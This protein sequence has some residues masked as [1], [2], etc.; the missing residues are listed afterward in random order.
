M[1]SIAGV[2]GTFSLLDDVTLNLI[3]SMFQIGIG[4]S[5]MYLV[6]ITLRVSAANELNKKGVDVEFVRKWRAQIGDPPKKLSVAKLPGP[7]AVVPLARRLQMALYCLSGGLGR[8][9]SKRW[10]ALALGLAGRFC[11]GGTSLN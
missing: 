6:I 5:M 7:A 1:L 3:P 9:V 8:V 4:L 10:G 11:M 2:W